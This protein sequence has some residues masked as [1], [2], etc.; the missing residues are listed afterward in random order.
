M[1]LFVLTALYIPFLPQDFSIYACISS[2]LYFISPV[3]PK[4]RYL[5][6][7]GT[8]T[9]R[10][11]SDAYDQI[12]RGYFAQKLCMN[13]HMGVLE[14]IPS[15][16]CVVETTHFWERRGSS[17]ACKA[18]S[19]RD[20]LKWEQG[21]CIVTSNSPLPAQMCMLAPQNEWHQTDASFPVFLPW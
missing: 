18:I 11:F 7:T 6:F 8:H 20:Q 15:L 19:K 10:C 14:E 13:K 2:P 21:S 9:S 3:L 12:R 1:P 4:Q 16:A 17:K 5:I